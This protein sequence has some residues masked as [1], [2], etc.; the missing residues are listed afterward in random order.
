MGREKRRLLLS[1]KLQYD[2]DLIG[3]ELPKF[4]IKKCG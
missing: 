4:Q 3:I 1:M 2:E